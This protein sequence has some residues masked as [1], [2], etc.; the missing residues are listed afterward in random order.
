MS[1]QILPKLSFNDDHKGKKLGR[2]ELKGVL[3]VTD[4]SAF[5]HTL[6]A[7]LGRARAYSSGLLLI[8]PREG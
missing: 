3:T 2:A 1:V 6:E 5:N 7:G 4:P 8:P